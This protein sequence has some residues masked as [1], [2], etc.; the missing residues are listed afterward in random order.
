M[1]EIFFGILVFALM[2]VGVS[3]LWSHADIFSPLRNWIARFTFLRKILLCPECCSFWIGLI[4]SFMFNP[5]AG[6]LVY[7]VH[8]MSHVFSGVITYLFASFLYKKSI[9]E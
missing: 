5:L 8:F 6:V 1:L 2:S 9:L 4:I 7:N 3:H